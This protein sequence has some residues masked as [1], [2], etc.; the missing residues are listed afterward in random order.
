MCRGGG[1]VFGGKLVPSSLQG[2]PRM[3]HP[4]HGRRRIIT[5]YAPL[6]NG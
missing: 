1:G 6:I 2:C 3:L 4:Q 5:V